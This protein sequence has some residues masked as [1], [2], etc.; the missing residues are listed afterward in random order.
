[1]GVLACI[2]PGSMAS[3]VMMSYRR[4][5]LMLSHNKHYSNALGRTVFVQIGVDY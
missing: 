5:M 3:I 4:I 1:M 2:L